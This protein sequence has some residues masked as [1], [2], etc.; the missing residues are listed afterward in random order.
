MKDVEIAKI[1]F[2]AKQ[3][4]Y[5]VTCA[6]FDTADHIF[7]LE[8]PKHLRRRKLAVQALHL[9]ADGLVK[10]GYEPA[11]RAASDEDEDEEESTN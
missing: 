10:Y 3:K 2:L 7:K 4:K 1:L 5:E 11:P 9:V 8:I 6:I